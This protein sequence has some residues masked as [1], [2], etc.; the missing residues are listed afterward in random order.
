MSLQIDI[1]ETRPGVR[2]AIIGGR[3]DTTTAPQLEAALDAIPPGTNLLIFDM[4]ALEYISSAGLRVI[5]KASKAVKTAGGRAALAHLQPQIRKVFD[6]V[7]AMPDV[8]IFSSAHEMD[9]YLDAMQQR[10]I[11]GEDTTI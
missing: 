7:K 10:V 2:Q 6:I 4:D 1:R 11:D 3:L 9:E 8:A 5:F